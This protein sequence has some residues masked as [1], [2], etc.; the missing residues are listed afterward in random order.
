MNKRQRKKKRKE[1]YRELIE[2]IALDISLNSQWRKRIFKL[3]LNVSLEISYK[4][5]YTLPEYIKE[6]IVF[7]KME[8]Y[9][10][11]V[12][13]SKRMFDIGLEIFKFQSKEYPE[14]TC[15]SGN[16]PQII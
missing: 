12:E 10:M 16:N 13:L 9:V 8:F 4:Y 3:P 11:R 1:K 7:N 2:D 15:Y 5:I 14:I 6:D